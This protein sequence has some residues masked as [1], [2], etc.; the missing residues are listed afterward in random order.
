[1]KTFIPGAVV[2]AAVFATSYA[3]AAAD[4][5]A[6]AARV[7]GTA[8]NA[9]DVQIL[10]DRMASAEG[11]G[12]GDAADTP[13]DPR[14]EA[15]ETLID[16]ELLT[17]QATADKV[18]V[19]AAEVDRRLAELKGRYPSPEMFDQALAA[20]KATEAD[21]R[22]DL[23][24]TLLMQKVLDTHVAVKLAPDAAEQFYKANTD[25][26]AHPAE[27]RASHILF[28]A[29]HDGDGD[30]AKQ[31]AVAALARVKKG[32]DFG[33]LAKELSD[34]TGS[35]DS[36][37]DLGFFPREG[38]VKEFAD[39]AFTLKKGE[40]SDV[41]KSQFGFHIIKTTD[42]RDAGTTPFAE[43]KPQIEAYLEAQQRNEQEH[44]YVDQLKKAAK[45]E[46]VESKASTKAEQPSA[47]SKAA[48]T[49]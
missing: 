48:A 1:M 23:K 2:L 29:P 45:I 14:K 37:G 15:L 10:A 46:I 19:S 12:G 13:A 5:A 6:V 31:K 8:I 33:A 42:T 43:V 18:E 36:G 47:A 27:V 16:Q 28:L 25:K 38:V 4:P 17:Q 9:A 22:K 34:D 21:L 26:F 30:A 24:T 39:A 11:P 35:K 3:V 41:V 44:A 32:E 7:N 40:V 20:S 49:E